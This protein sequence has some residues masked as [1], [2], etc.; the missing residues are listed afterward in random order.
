MEKFNAE[1]DLLSKYMKY[2]IDCSEVRAKC[3]FTTTY[4]HGKEILSN[5]KLL[6]GIPTFE[7]FKNNNII[8]L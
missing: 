3:D 2:Y 5:K 7:D 4:F 8:P 1:L 6:F